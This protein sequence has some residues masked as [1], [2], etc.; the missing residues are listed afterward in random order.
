MRFLKVLLPILLSSSVFASP[1]L[2][3]ELTARLN[4][5]GVIVV[6][7]DSPVP[8]EIP[9]SQTGKT[10][11]CLKQNQEDYNLYPITKNTF[12]RGEVAVLVY[13]RNGLFLINKGYI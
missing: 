1:D 13:C 4:V 9:H 7:N 10:L 2:Q 12:P 11:F 5:I 6:R 8:L 3:T